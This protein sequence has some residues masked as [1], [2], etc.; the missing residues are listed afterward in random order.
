MTHFSVA[1]FEGDDFELGRQHGEQFAEQVGVQ[2]A[3][4]LAAAVTSG[5]P[6]DAALAWS[7]AQLPRIAASGPHW[8]DELRGLA[9]GAGISLAEAA[10]LQVRPGSGA[11]PEGCTSFAAAGDATADGCPLAGQNRDVVPAYRRRMFVAIVR[12]RSRPAIV[13]HHVPGELGGVGMNAH[14]V[15]VLANSLWATSG[16]TWMAPPILRRAVLEC[17]TAD[18]A[19]ERVRA[20]AGPAVGSFLIADAAGR[21]RNVECLPEAVAVIAR[22]R[23]V[24]AHA[25]NCTVPETRPHEAART[26]APGSENRRV[27]MQSL[28]EREA[29]R[30]SVAGAKALLS[31]H[32]SQPEPL[33]RHA[34]SERQWETAAAVVFELARGRMHLSYGPPCGGRFAEIGLGD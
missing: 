29:G 21:I 12:P 22:D 3:E 18:E 20:M 31:D 26:P 33:C 25:N 15:C 27:C 32:S 23:G 34:S 30:L 8:I 4:T 28:L 13:M 16:R 7:A 10:A 2:L 9:A 19:A 5:L 14:G 24:Y 6:R 11:M 17:A 1:R